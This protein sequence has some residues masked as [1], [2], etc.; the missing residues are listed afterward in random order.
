M[1]HISL[2]NLNDKNM[3]SSKRGFLEALLSDEQYQNHLE[4]LGVSHP[5]FD[6]VGLGWDLKF[7]I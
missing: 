4:G 1:Q 7:F 6:S 5:E 3:S 2:D